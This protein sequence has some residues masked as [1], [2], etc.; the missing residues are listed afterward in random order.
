MSA[1]ENIAT[2]DRD[3]YTIAIHY[4]PDCPNPREDAC[5]LGVFIGLPHRRYRIG[6][7]QIDPTRHGFTCPD[8]TGTGWASPTEPTSGADPTTATDDGDGACPACWGEG[9]RT[10]R[11]M[12]E[13]AQL[14]RAERGARVLLPVGMLDHS[15][16]TYYIGSGPHRFDPQGWDSGLAGFICDTPDGLATCW[17]ETRPADEQIAAGLTGE[18]EVYSQWVGGQ[19]Y[20]YTLT[21]PHG[22]EIDACWGYLGLDSWFDGSGY[23]IDAAQAAIDADRAAAHSQRPDQY[24]RMVTP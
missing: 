16:I 14:L 21:D 13:F 12:R 8:C 22:E 18:I 15:G 6:D 20:G 2:F 23:L 9:Y 4:D 24:R 11:S 19:C 5:T 1:L 7:E 17:G 10:A 3:G